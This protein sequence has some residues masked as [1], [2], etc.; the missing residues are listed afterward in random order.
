MSLRTDGLPLAFIGKTKK[1]YQ[2]DDHE[3][4]LSF[5]NTVTGDLIIEDG[6][7]TFVENPGGNNESP[8]EVE[9]LGRKNLEASVKFFELLAARN[10]PTHMI[11]FDLGEGT[12]LVKE[13]E[14]IGKGKACN[15]KG[16]D[17]TV[18]GLECIIRFKARG[19]FIG[20]D[21][22]I[23][24]DGSRYEDGDILL[25]PRFDITLKNDAANDPR[26]TKEELLKDEIMT[27]AQYDE[28][29]KTVLKA[30]TVIKEYF[31]GLY[32]DMDDIKFEVA[33]IDGQLTIIDEISAGIM[34]V[35]QKDGVQLSESD[36]ADVIVTEIVPNTSSAF[37]LI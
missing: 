11:D 29:H 23:K 18:A 35:Y 27:E 25:E 6:K 24:P 13:G 28:C 9:G 20:R 26:A 37:S 31:A 2:S 19:S 15:I 12:M 1:G 5:K 22:A 30:A 7:Q 33:I 16:T 14:H 8:Y 36:L 32:L 4:L 17:Y 21:D 34:R 3:I 10:I